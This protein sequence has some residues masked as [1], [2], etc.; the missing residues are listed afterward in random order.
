MSV[1]PL[2]IVLSPLPTGKPST[3]IGAVTRRVLPQFAELLDPSLKD[4]LAGHAVFAAAWRIAK[5]L[6][7][8]EL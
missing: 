7:I 4:W 8:L 5:R 2:S 6:I 1:H 3:L